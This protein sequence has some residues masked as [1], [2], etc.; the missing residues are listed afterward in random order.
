M[1]DLKRKLEAIR[2]LARARV[3]MLNEGSCCYDEERKAFYLQEYDSKIAELDRLLHDL[4]CKPDC[5]HQADKHEGLKKYWHRLFGY[6]GRQ[7]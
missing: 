3:R 4:H 7:H 5:P 6:G 1:E 2:D